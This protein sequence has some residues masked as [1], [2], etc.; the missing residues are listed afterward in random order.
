M[1]QDIKYNEVLNQINSH[2]MQTSKYLEN[3]MKNYDKFDEQSA[4]ISKF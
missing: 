4:D 3:Y 2:P 1:I